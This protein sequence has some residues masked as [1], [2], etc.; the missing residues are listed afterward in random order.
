M[1]PRAARG[2]GTEHPAIRLVLLGTPRLEL[3]DRPAVALERR[4][5]ALLA[6]LAIDG[7]TP[8]AQAAALLW[9]DADDKSARNNLRQ[10]LF[11]LRQAAQRDVVVPDT[12]LA[13]AEGIAHDLSDLSTHLA[14]DAEAASGELLGALCL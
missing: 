12:T 5:A 1:A 10:R 2:N 8:R 11:R 3:A 14:A 7:P 9:P 6:K 13:L 4:M